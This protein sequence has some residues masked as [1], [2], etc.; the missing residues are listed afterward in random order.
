MK[1][2]NSCPGEKSVLEELD[3]FFRENF[4]SKNFLLEKFL[5]RKLFCQK[6]FTGN[7][8]PEKFVS[9]TFRRKSLRQKLSAGK[10]CARHFSTRNF[11]RRKIFQ[12]KLFC[13]KK[14]PEFPPSGKNVW[15]GNL[16]EFWFLVHLFQNYN[17]HKKKFWELHIPFFLI[18]LFFLNH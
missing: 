4:L 3:W 2:L 13:W 10:V 18:R 12:R 14:F 6:F 15:Y 1:N 7:F 8:L 16:P 11:F 5:P 9:E 17:F